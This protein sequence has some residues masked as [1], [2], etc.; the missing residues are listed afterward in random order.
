[1]K[2]QF[3]FDFNRFSRPTGYFRL[4]NCVYQLKQ[5]DEA[6][7]LSYLHSDK[8]CPNAPRILSAG[9]GGKN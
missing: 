6:K 5:N 3:V 7:D 4:R 9:N 1:M 2:N 8:M